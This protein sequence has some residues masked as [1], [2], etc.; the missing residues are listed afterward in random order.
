MRPKSTTCGL[1][2]R[3]CLRAAAGAL[4]LV[5]VLAVP[6]LALAHFGRFFRA[7][8]ST[9]EDWDE[10]HGR[11]SS[12]PLTFDAPRFTMT[13]MMTRQREWT[14]QDSRQGEVLVLNNWH[15]TSSDS[16]T[17]MVV[18]FHRALCPVTPCQ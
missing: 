4:A 2:W 17:N 16:L 11:W 13:R 14:A 10:I 8:E 3:R 12:Q 15:F 5:T 9:E 18:V 6:A 1:T 7:A